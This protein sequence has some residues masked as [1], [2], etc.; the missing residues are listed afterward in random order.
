MNRQQQL[1][2]ERSL[3]ANSISD[4]SENEAEHMYRD[5]R[6]NNLATHGSWPDGQHA[7][8]QQ[9]GWLFVISAML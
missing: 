6:S 8:T 4:Q 2:G 7:R 5:N 9:R 3:H 1:L